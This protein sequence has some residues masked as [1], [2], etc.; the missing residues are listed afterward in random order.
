[1][2]CAFVDF[3]KAFDLVYRDGIWYKLLQ[4]GASSKFANMLKAIYKKVKS[5][6]KVH[7]NLSRYFESYMGVKQ[8]GPLSPLLFILFINDMETS[9]YD[10]SADLVTF[11]EFKLFLLLFADDTVIFSYTEQGLQVLVRR[12][13]NYCKTWGITVN[14]DKT[15]LMVFKSGNRPETVDIFFDNCKLKNV[16]KFTYLGV[17]L[18]ANGKFYQAQK[19]LRIF[20]WTIWR[21]D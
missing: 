15:V 6:I 17:T 4:S 14:T 9:I 7:G 10:Q 2:Y 13:E 21:G 5:C 3:K 18:S 1:M 11:D 19:A 8:G 20:M 16:S 12:L